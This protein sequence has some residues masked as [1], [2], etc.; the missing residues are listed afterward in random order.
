M[1][2]RVFPV[3]PGAYP[4]VPSPLLQGLLESRGLFP[5]EA[6]SRAKLGPECMG[7]E[8]MSKTAPSPQIPP[9]QVQEVDTEPPER[10]PSLFCA[11]GSSGARKSLGWKDGWSGEGC[12]GM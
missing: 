6:V 7:T 1:P 10:D 8:L 4:C 12:R 2:Q 9:S 11:A 5:G 3:V